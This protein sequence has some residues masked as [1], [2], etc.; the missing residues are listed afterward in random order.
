MP[1]DCSATSN[2]FDG[3]IGKENRQFPF[4]FLHFGFMIGGL[5]RGRRTTSGIR[6][7]S[8]VAFLVRAIGP[9]GDYPGTGNAPGSS[10]E[11]SARVRTLFVIP[12]LVETRIQDNVRHQLDVVPNAMSG[13]SLGCQIIANKTRHFREKKETFSKYWKSN[14][15]LEKCFNF[16]L[17]L[18]ILLRRMWRK[19]LFTSLR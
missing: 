15:R 6:E 14:P 16:R 18:K 3:G 8:T 7:S 12:R 1:E 19:K 10:E 11:N 5:G 13:V 4:E 17:F 9:S 2:P